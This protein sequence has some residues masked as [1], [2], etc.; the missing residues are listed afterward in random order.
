MDTGG[1]SRPR[2]DLPHCQ[3]AN[4]YYWHQYRTNKTHIGPIRAC[5]ENITF[6]HMRELWRHHCDIWPIRPKFQ[7]RCRPR[8]WLVLPI[9]NQHKWSLVKKYSLDDW[10]R[11]FCIIFFWRHFKTT[12]WFIILQDGQ[13]SLNVVGLLM[14]S[15]PNKCG[16]YSTDPTMFLK[17]HFSPREWRHKCDI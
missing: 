8:S 4:Y 16:L 13:S 7:T 1:T 12:S 5:F 9:W 2:Q 6:S 14:A 15:I 3:I 17:R 10:C 11:T